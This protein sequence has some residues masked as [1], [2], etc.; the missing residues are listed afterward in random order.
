MQDTIIKGTGDSRTLGSVPNFLEVFPS[1]QAFGQ[2]LVSGLVPIDLGPLNPLSCKQIGTGYTKAEVLSD[3]TAELL[4][5]PDTVNE[6]LRRIPTA[7]TGYVVV[8]THTEDGE[9][10]PDV[11]VLF[12][13]VFAGNTGPF[14]IARFSVPYGKHTVTVVR[15]LDFESVTQ[16]IE[17]VSISNI[18][19][20]NIDAVCVLSDVTSIQITDSGTYGFSGRVQDFD[21]FLVGAGSSGAVTITKTYSG[22]FAVGG[23]GGYTTTKKKIQNVGTMFDLTIG[24]SPKNTL[25]SQG[26]RSPLP[27]GKTALT[28]LDETIEALGGSP[29]GNDHV[30]GNGG[31]GGASANATSTVTNLKASDAGHDGSNG[32][33]LTASEFSTGQGSTTKAFGEDSGT[34][35]SPGGGSIALGQYTS[36]GIVV[37]RGNVTQSGASESRYA[38]SDIDVSAPISPIYGA[39]GGGVLIVGYTSRVATSQGT[40]GVAILRWRWKAA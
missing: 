5:G 36:G 17:A 32:A 20:I 8:T 30:G 39:G 40:Q 7:N 26:S 35:Y 21:A 15:C 24:A 25:S 38:T 12:D 19:A 33:A 9:A 10:V 29:S 6:A 16:D 14:G 2:G 11:P 1:Y 28:I 3:E 27:G 18:T 13:G 37:E 22:S 31:S 4:G 23:G 34:P